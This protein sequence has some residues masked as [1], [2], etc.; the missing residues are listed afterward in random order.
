MEGLRR[1]LRAVSGWVSMCASRSSLEL[2]VLKQMGQGRSSSSEPRPATASSA[3]ASSA[4]STH[5]NLLSPLTEQTSPLPDSRRS[6]WGFYLLVGRLLSVLLLEALPPLHGRTAAFGGRGW[7]DGEQAAGRVLLVNL[8]VS[9][10][11]NEGTG[12]LTSPRVQV[13]FTCMSSKKTQK[14]CRV[15]VNLTRN[16]GNSGKA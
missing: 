6:R 14:T 15:I 1:Y 13:A 4:T 9:E 11:R 3:V 5:K 7:A 8:H 16:A 2:Q 10:T 12:E